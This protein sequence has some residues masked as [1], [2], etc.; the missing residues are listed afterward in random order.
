MPAIPALQLPHQQQMP[1]LG[2]GTYQLKGD[3]CEN[4]VQTA[5]SIGYRHIDT[6]DFYQN[7]AAVGAG[8][9]SSGV[10]RKEI[11]VTS[12]VWRDHLHYDDV[13]SNCRRALKEMNL[14][15][16]DL[17]LIH[18]PNNAIPLE[19][20]LRA[21]TKLVK[22]GLIKNYG[23]SNFTISRMKEALKLAEVPIANNQVEYHAQLNQDDL[24]TFCQKNNVTVTAYSPLAQGGS[25]KDELLIEIGKKHNKNASQIALRWMVQK[26]IAPVPK[27]STPERIKGN[28]EIFDFELT[29]A[30]MKAINERKERKR[31]ITWD[32][33]DFDT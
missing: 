7:H 30:E 10:P 20:T 29:A 1:I 21:M 26:N 14:E 28:F 13:I 9:K 23:V 4:A 32:V 15:Y 2:F 24:R 25:A 31:L 22:D 6:A 3:A 19:E 33:A 17:W 8:I 16:L 18:W 27:A 12:K 5:L 11:F